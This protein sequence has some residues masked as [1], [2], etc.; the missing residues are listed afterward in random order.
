MGIV[1]GRWA[2]AESEEEP[3]SDIQDAHE[4]M[5]PDEW[6][7][8]EERGEVMSKAPGPV[9]LYLGNKYNHD[10][11]PT[12]LVKPETYAQPWPWAWLEGDDR[13]GEREGGEQGERGQKMM[14]YGARR[15]PG[16]EES[17]W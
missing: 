4:A 9:R 7:G 2:G 8:E 6:G 12:G 5:W 10:I 15:E 3:E 17:G 11:L 1:K 13:A 16:C 14:R